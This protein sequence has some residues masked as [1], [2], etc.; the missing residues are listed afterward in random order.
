M[1]SHNS[2]SNN[3]IL[4]LDSGMM[5]EDFKN[6]MISSNVNKIT[7]IKENNFKYKLFTFEEKS[8]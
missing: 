2:E 3:W 6:V 8:L 7:S 1:I 5:K 4:V